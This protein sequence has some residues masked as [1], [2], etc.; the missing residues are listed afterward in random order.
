MMNDNSQISWSWTQMSYLKTKI[1]EERAKVT[2]VI[3]MFRSALYR[4]LTNAGCRHVAYGIL[5]TLYGTIRIP[6]IQDLNFNQN[7]V[8]VLP[9]KF[10]QKSK[11]GVWSFWKIYKSESGLRMVRF[12]NQSPDKD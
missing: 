12:T 5:H 8:N 7:P 11:S 9:L 4:L 3:L 2:T 6:G 1:F 10:L